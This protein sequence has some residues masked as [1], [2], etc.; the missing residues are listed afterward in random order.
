M[1]ANCL[2]PLDPE[3]LEKNRL[4]AVAGANN[5]T[6]NA[7]RVAGNRPELK[8]RLG[9]MDRRNSQNQ[10]NRKSRT[11]NDQRLARVVA[12]NGSGDKVT[13]ST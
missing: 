4:I 11:H 8:R 10:V 3:P 5:K 12:A 13:P 1:T 7:K 9:T 2:K 6:A